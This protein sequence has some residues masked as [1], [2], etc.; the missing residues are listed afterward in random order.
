MADTKAARGILLPCP[1]CGELEA[2]I[3]LNLADGDTLTCSECDTEFG[4][5]DI[6][7]LVTRWAPV[8]SWLDGMPAG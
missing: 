4:R 2:T 3:S 7:A 6:R 1:R 5:E 8:L